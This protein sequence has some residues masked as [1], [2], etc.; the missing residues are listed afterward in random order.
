M[1]SEW[2]VMRPIFEFQDW[3][4]APMCVLI[5]VTSFG[6]VNIIIGVIVERTTL[7]MESINAQLEEQEKQVMMGKI[8][9]MAGDIWAL[10]HNNDGFISIEEMRGISESPAALAHFQDLKLPKG[11]TF[12]DLFDM[13]NLSGSE[14]LN[15]TEFIDGMHRIVFTTDFHINCFLLQGM[16][17]AKK[18][19]RD[20]QRQIFEQQRQYLEVKFADLLLELQV[21]IADLKPGGRQLSLDSSLQGW[22]AKEEKLV[23]D[24][25]PGLSLIHI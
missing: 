16:G 25:S 10:D 23:E 18:Q 19:R 12:D 2:V 21:A 20:M 11:F 24:D 3:L 14:E 1:L 9:L 22:L 13:L 6:I 17:Q 15:H 8:R 4:I 5:F 7:A